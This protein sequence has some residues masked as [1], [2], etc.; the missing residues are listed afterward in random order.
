ME[1]LQI[2]SV[3]CHTCMYFKRTMARQVNCLAQ[4]SIA[5]RRVIPQQ[6]PQP[7]LHPFQGACGSSNLSRACPW[8]VP[9]PCRAQSG[10]VDGSFDDSTDDSA[11]I[12]SPEADELVKKLQFEIKAKNTADDHVA[13]SAEILKKIAEEAKDEMDR[14]TELAKMRGDL[15]FDQ[16]LADLNREADMFERKLKRQREEMERERQET[17]EWMRDVGASRNQGQFFGNLYEDEEGVAG[18]AKRWAEMDDVERREA[19]ER[20]KKILETTE[21]EIRSPAR[22]YIFGLLGGML[23]VNVLADVAIGAD[24][25]GLDV[26]YGVLA[27]GSLYLMLNEQK[28]LDKLN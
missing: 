25:V 4:E 27:C 20:R 14:A 24:N 21:E 22:M 15:A 13:E 17:V 11:V 9:H 12:P 18:R 3:H 1:D 2:Y 28:E 23:V 5:Q 16:A 26:L 6:G 8:F 10:D 7:R 19:I